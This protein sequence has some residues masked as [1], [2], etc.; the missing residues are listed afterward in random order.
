MKQGYAHKGYYKVPL[1]ECY[2]E[3]GEEPVGTKWLEGNWR[4]SLQQRRRGKQRRCCEHS[5]LQKE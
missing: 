2:Y 1:K 4:R 5:R 3:A